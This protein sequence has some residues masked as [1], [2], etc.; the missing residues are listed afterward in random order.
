MKVQTT[1]CDR[2]CFYALK[3]KVRNK[4]LEICKKIGYYISSLGL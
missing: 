4:A 3:I 2:K 1:M